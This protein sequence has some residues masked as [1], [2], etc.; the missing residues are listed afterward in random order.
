M[1]HIEFE[2]TIYL[3]KIFPNALAILCLNNPFLGKTAR[4]SVSLFGAEKEKWENILKTGDSIRISGN[5]AEAK[6][7][8]FG[9]YISIYN[10]E[11]LEVNGV[12]NHAIEEL[13]TKVNAK[14][15]EQE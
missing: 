5:I 8:K 4:F 2:A 10:P 7:N 11:I 9:A 14:D 15:Q 12:D 1:N 3:L 13:D 6:Q